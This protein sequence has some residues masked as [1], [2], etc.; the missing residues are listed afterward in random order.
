M[1]FVSVGKSKESTTKDRVGRRVNWN[2]PPGM[3]V[4]AEYWLVG[5]EITVITIVEADSSAAIMASIA[6]WDD[7][8]D[9]QV[10]PALTAEEG[11]AAAEQMAE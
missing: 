2:Y 7:V 6:D 1:L 11:L 8:F 10:S 9:F 5:G 4:L 3:N